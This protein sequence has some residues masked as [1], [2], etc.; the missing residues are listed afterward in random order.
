MCTDYVFASNITESMP[1]N[2]AYDIP[3]G[4]VAVCI[5]LVPVTIISLII[6]YWRLDMNSETRE[7]LRLAQLIRTPVAIEEA[8]D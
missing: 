8:K 6:V 2:D 7:E 4:I 3:A 5:I 1:R